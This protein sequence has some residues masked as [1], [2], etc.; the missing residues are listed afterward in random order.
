MRFSSLARLS[1]SAALLL[2]LGTFVQASP[3]F[4]SNHAND[5]LD[6]DPCAGFRITF[7]TSADLVFEDSSKHVVAWQAPETLANIDISLVTDESNELVQTIGG[8]GAER[9]ASDEVPLN[10]GDHPTGKY[11]YKLVGSTETTT[12]E[13]SSTP[14]T[15][16]KREVPAAD[17]SHENDAA[18]DKNWSE[19]L[20]KVDEYID[21]DGSDSSSEKHTNAG[22]NPYFTNED[23]RNSHLDSDIDSLEANKHTNS[24]FFTNADQR[25]HKDEAHWN[26][27]GGNYFTNEDSRTTVHD[28]SQASWEEPS[29]VHSDEGH[30]NTEEIDVESVAHQD[31]SNWESPDDAVPDHSDQGHWNSEVIEDVNA[32]S[33]EYDVSDESH[34]NGGHWNGDGQD[35]TESHWDSEEIDVEPEFVEAHQDAVEGEWHSDDSAIPDHSDEGHWNS[36]EIDAEIHNFT[37]HEDGGWSE[38]ADSSDYDHSDEQGHWN[39]EEIDVESIAH[40]DAS[41]WESLDDVVPDHSDQGHWNS[42][43][44]DDVNAPSTEYDVSDESHTNGGHWNGD[45]QDLTES[46]WDSEEIDVEPEFVEAHQDAVEGEWHSDDSAIPDHSD[47]GHWNSE[48]IDAEIHN[49]TPHEDG[50]WSEDAD[51]SDYDHSDEQ[52]HWN[53]EEIDVE[54]IAHQDASNWES[55]DDVVP[56]HSDQGHWN[57]DVIDDVNAS[58]EWTDADHTDAANAWSEDSA[59]HE[60]QGHW[61]SEEIDVESELSSLHEDLVEGQWQSND[62]IP[63]HSNEG[64]WHTDS[65]DVEDDGLTGWSEEN[66]DDQHSDATLTS[67]VEE[68]RNTHQNAGWSEDHVDSNERSGRIEEGFADSKTSNVHANSVPVMTAEELI[69]NW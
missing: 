23:H 30:W 56:D 27:E 3:F 18:D 25:T 4:Q 26:A 67:V 58:N 68:L 69:A 20:D 59:P 15:I 1:T 33:T 51:S 47:E 12:C 55:L 37:P 24:P 64:T 63:D 60:D 40:Q 14:F 2:Q 65:I 43:V 39:T 57:S 38:D 17:E 7:P 45:G 19:M 9:G 10:L 8:Y 31:A 28:D 29:E 32:P 5:A 62:N 50:G 35:L 52:G 61:N 48:E 22:S 54:S 13:L 66:N 34:T 41:N 53:T 11:H 44:I 36:E 21:N 16:N 42:E 46:H 6:A 49:F